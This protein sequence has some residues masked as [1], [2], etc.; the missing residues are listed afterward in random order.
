MREKEKKHQKLLNG[1][2]SEKRLKNDQHINEVLVGSAIL[3]PVK[4]F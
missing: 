1:R 3:L 4:H 2:I